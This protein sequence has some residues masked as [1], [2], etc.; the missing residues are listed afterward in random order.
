MNIGDIAERFGLATHVLRH[1]EAVGLL[2]PRRQ[3]GRRRYGPDELWRVAVILR[4]KEAGIS[5][6]DIREMM[7]DQDPEA[8]RAILQRRQ[9]DLQRRIAEARTALD[10][11]ECALDCDHADFT[12]CAQFQAMVS[13]RIGGQPGGLR[14]DAVDG[15]HR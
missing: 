14:G 8:R 13:A 3:A 1:W 6:E 7:A 11:I 10:L 12:Q 2:A 5:L 15:A 9:A 4:A